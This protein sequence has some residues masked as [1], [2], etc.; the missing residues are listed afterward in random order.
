M[1]IF[2]DIAKGIRDVDKKGHLQRRKQR[3]KKK[4]A[5]AKA[6]GDIAEVKKTWR[7]EENDYEKKKKGSERNK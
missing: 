1:S 2:D 5:K 6:R 3:Q 4:Q 7:K